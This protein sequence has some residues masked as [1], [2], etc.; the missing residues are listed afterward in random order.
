VSGRVSMPL[1][2]GGETQ[3]RVRAAKHTHVARLQ[4]IEQA[5]SESNALAITA[6]SRLNAARAQMQSDKVGVDA[7]RTA[8]EGT[9]EEERVGQRTLLDVLNAEQ[10]LLDAEVQQVVTKREVIVASFTLL[11]AIGRLNAD[12]LKL[13]NS[14]YD[15][16]V[17]YEEVQ[18]K[19]WGISTTHASGRTEILDMMDD[20]SAPDPYA[21]PIRR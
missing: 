20:W 19:W 10:E 12:E 7:A 17:H 1:Y 6:W 8:L 11:A 21:S 18:R 5:R 14:V 3:A 15:P 16:E 4:E 9:R 2:E 13:T